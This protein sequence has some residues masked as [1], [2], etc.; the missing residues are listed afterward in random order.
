MR[1][2]C[3]AVGLWFCGCG[4]SPTPTYYTLAAVRGTIRQAQVGPIEVR[5]PAV[6]GYLDRTEILERWDGLRMQLANDACWGEPIAA[7]IGR[8]LA[9]DLSER[10]RD[11][12]AFSS[13][14]DL[15]VH[16]GTVIELMIQKFDLAFD[17]RVH[18]HVL[19]SVRGARQS[20]THA[21]QLQSRPIEADTDAIVA[22]MSRLLGQLADE[23]AKV[24]ASTDQAVDAKPNAGLDRAHEMP[25]TDPSGDG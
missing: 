4:S 22:A 11:T 19:W 10:L 8:V 2:L 1:A 16:A 13:S 18:L 6:A 12:I 17:G 25:S 15:T 7:M 9:E 21:L 3:V 5:R 20:S 23:I 14:S 24:L